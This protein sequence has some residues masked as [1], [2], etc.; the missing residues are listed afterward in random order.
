MTTRRPHEDILMSELAKLLKQEIAAGLSTIF[1]DMRPFVA[2]G[3]RPAESFAGNLNVIINNNV[4]AAVTA[5]ES[6]GPFGQKQLEI[7]IDQMVARAL[8]GGRETSGVMR[9]LFGL[10]PGLIGR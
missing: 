7:T 1:A 4:S 3:Q 8:V 5:R 10:V 2:S 6:S 9:S